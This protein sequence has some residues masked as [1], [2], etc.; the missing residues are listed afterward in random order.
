V[1]TSVAELAL[2]LQQAQ[3]KPVC[4]LMQSCGMKV[5][6]GFPDVKASERELL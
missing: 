2:G 1:L 6:D 3:F 5:L 4:L